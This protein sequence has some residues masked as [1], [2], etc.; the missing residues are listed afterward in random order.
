[1]IINASHLELV[2]EVDI[3][4][5]LEK[6]AVNNDRTFYLILNEIKDKKRS[7]P[8]SNA[9]QLL[10]D[11]LSQK[12]IPP[13]KYYQEI[14]DGRNNPADQFQRIIRKALIN[15]TAHIHKRLLLLDPLEFSMRIK[16]FNKLDISM[17]LK[18][19]SKDP[20][21]LMQLLMHSANAEFRFVKDEKETFSLM[22]E[23]DSLL[24]KE[25]NQGIA[26]ADKHERFTENEFE[27]EHPLFSIAMIVPGTGIN[28]LNAGISYVK[29]EDIKKLQSIMDRPEIKKIVPGNTE[30][31][32]FSEPFAHVDGT[33][34]YILYCV[35]KICL[36]TNDYF[37][38]L[39]KGIDAESYNVNIDIKMNPEGIEKWMNLKDKERSMVLIFSQKIYSEPF[40][41]KRISEE[42]FQLSGISG[43][44]KARSA[45]TIINAAKPIIP[46]KIISHKFKNR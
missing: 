46:L 12:N 42:R 26:S 2:L 29:E 13:A 24:A 17:S 36:M 5:F 31:I 32:F 11:G 44:E 25:R 10:T 27:K 35:D 16:G 7:N 23:I 3:P 39:K 20:G 30:F 43:L 21:N 14:S 4:E 45:E 37:T 8:N 22:K 38:V 18:P 41:L 28:N 33:D 9:L 1:M 19:G 6:T 40:I 34:I 15:D